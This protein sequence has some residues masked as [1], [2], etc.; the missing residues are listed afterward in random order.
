VGKR[1]VTFEPD[2]KLESK[3]AT[4]TTESKTA[5]KPKTKANVAKKLLKMKIQV[6]K[7][8]NFD[9]EGQTKGDIHRERQSDLAKSYEKQDL[10]GIDI[11]TAKAVLKLEDQYDKQIFRERI[12]AKHRYVPC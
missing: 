1:A 10:S 2:E 9:E 8:V 11:E 6:N 12:R 7:V 5:K 4:G 3:I